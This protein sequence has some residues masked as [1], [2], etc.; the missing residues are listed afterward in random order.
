MFK[1]SHAIHEDKACKNPILSFTV[2]EQVFSNNAIL[3]ISIYIIHQ[4]KNKQFH[5]IHCLCYFPQSKVNFS[6]EKS[7]HNSYEHVKIISWLLS[8]KTSIKVVNFLP[9]TQSSLSSLMNLLHFK[10]LFDFH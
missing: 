4:K 8:L 6:K 9:R 10:G 5:C 7:P 1:N 2:T 3:N